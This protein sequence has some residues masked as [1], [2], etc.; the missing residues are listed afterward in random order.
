MKSDPSIELKD[1]E[2]VENKS[3]SDMFTELLNNSGN[4]KYPAQTKELF[5]QRIS[6]AKES[7]AEGIEVSL[8]FDRIDFVSWLY[9]NQDLPIS[10]FIPEFSEI[11]SN[12]LFHCNVTFFEIVLQK[13]ALFLLYYLYLP[14][15]HLRLV[16]IVVN[17]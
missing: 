3:L 10:S 15:I 1:N 11:L 16:Q 12:I 8:T 2:D 4:K 9:S 7:D 17:A 5:R 14:F 6:L 13:Y